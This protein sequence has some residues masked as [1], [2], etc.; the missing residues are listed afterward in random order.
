MRVMKC[1]LKI[2][3]IALML[4]TGLLRWIASLRLETRWVSNFSA[5]PKNADGKIEDFDTAPLV[6]CPIGYST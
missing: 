2:P 5:K 6:A 4:A 1:I 3:A